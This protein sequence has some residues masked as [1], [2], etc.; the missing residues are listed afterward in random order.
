M[1]RM[2]KAD[3]TFLDVDT[4]AR[5]AY[6]ARISRPIASEHESHTPPVESV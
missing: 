2:I 3:R 6:D 4:S 1:N 5:A